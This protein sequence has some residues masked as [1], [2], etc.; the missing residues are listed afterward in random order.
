MF[1]QPKSGILIILLYALGYYGWIVTFSD[2]QFLETLGGNIFSISGL[3]IALLYLRI[4]IK[5]ADSNDRKFWLLIAFGTFC[6]LIAE[7]IWFLAESVFFTEM[8]FPGWPD[9]FYI[10]QVFIL[11]YALI[12][13]FLKD[14]AV[15]QRISF[16]F[17]VMIVL[18]VASTFSW[19]FLIV[20][21]IDTSAATTEALII[22]LAYPLGDI[23]MLVASSFL[24]FNLTDKGKNMSTYLII[25]AVTIQAIA[26]SVYL[27]LIAQDTYISGSLIDPLFIIALMILA[28]AGIQHQPDTKSTRSAHHPESLN[29][30][31][32]LTPYGGVLILF[33]FMGF[34]SRS[35]DIVTVGSGLSI[36]LVI[37]RQ[38]FIIIENHKL[39]GRYYEQAQALELS[40]ERYK[41]LFEYHPDPVYSTDLKGHFD[42]ANA[43]CSDL[44]GVAQSDLMGQHS[45]Q[46]VK[47][48]HRTRVAQELKEVFKGAPRNYETVIENAQGSSMYMNITNVP[49]IVQNEI[50][51]IFGISKDVTE[52]QKTQ[53]RIHYLAYHDTL[54]GLFNRFAFE[55][56]LSALIEIDSPHPTSNVSL[57]FMDLN[58]FK[59][60]ND[61]LGHD[62][63]DQLLRAVAK[64]LQ[65]FET[66]FDMMARQGGDEFTLLLKDVRSYEQL[67]HTADELLVTLQASYQIGSHVIFCPPSIGISCYPTDASSM[68]EMLQ[69]ADFAMYRAK[70]IPSG[71]YVLYDEL[72]HMPS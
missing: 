14:A 67:R 46:Y 61:T 1:K 69:H 20:P 62:V 3:L 55:E 30:F 11:F 17:D 47:E 24:F 36:L 33:I 52:V 28:F 4:A 5:R 71:S 38:V 72:Q 60:V 54:T 56:R 7:V 9:V 31:Q 8:T 51:G 58:Q 42:T 64:R 6:Y 45:L 49:I 40:E 2:S 22:S 70:D 66:D 12:Y 43:A 57:F 23:G 32:L 41:S 50:V 18:V 39:V 25:A 35:F 63:G 37:T 21:I 13:K 19:H 48:T 53:Q 68:L 10:L 59:T 15:Q 65:S 27:Y 44:L 26:D 29:I 16:L 34:H